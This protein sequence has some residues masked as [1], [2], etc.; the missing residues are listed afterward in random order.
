M[1]KRKNQRFRDEAE[2]K[3]N[4]AR[5][6]F[7]LKSLA[8]AGLLATLGVAGWKT[9]DSSRSVSFERA[10]ANPDLRE[11]WL[12]N[13][14]D[15]RPYVNKII[16]TSEHLADLKRRL[17][18]T[19]QKGMSAATVMRDQSKVTHG[20]ISDVFVYDDTFNSD[21]KGFVKGWGRVVENII[22]NHEL[23]HA[24]H[25][26]SGISGYPN[27]W[28]FDKDGKIDDNM[29]RALLLQVSEVVAH[30]KEYDGLVAMKGKDE[31][32]NAYQHNLVKIAKPIFVLAYALA[33]GNKDLQD[34]IKREA[35]F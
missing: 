24:D 11:R 9:Y 35:W 14:T 22:N 25:W 20:A 26:Y 27:E 21:F 34:N 29:K 30:R 18:Y 8:G 33:K 6:N 17:D 15:T 32:V 5:R 23:V 12:Q 16:A 4:L 3:N 13:S 31:F 10:Y 28:F 7:L 19:P 1:G 2:A